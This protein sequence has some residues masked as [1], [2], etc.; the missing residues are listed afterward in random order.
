[1]DDIVRE[2]VFA[3]RNEDLRTGYAEGAIG[4]RYCTGAQKSEVG[5]AMRL[6]QTHGSRPFAGSQLRQV[7]RPLRV[8]A[9]SRQACVSRLR[10]TRIRG[11]GHVSASEYLHDSRIDRVR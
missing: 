3:S 4:I 11:P 8:R 9:I 1:M 6:G 2:V 7:E 5:A 10:H